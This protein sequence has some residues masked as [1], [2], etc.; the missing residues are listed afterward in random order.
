LGIMC[1]HIDAVVKKYAFMDHAEF[2]R[3]AVRDYLLMEDESG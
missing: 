3:E 2:I 1:K